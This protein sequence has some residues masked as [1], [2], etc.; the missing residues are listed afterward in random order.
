MEHRVGLTLALWQ[1]QAVLAFDGFKRRS[2]QTGNLKS[3]R[4]TL[5]SFDDL[6]IIIQ[7]MESKYYRP[8]EERYAAI[9]FNEIYRF[10]EDS[11]A[12]SSEANIPVNCKEIISFH[13]LLIVESF[14]GPPS[15]NNPH[16]SRPFDFMRLHMKNTSSAV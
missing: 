2:C 4:L 14:D 15:T 11:F 5:N 9:L 1:S 16:S 10:N 3:R 6:L 12:S 8:Y 7:T 13:S